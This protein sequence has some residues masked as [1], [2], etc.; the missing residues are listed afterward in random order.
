MTLRFRVALF[1]SAIFLL[2]AVSLYLVFNATLMG[3]FLSLENEGVQRN[4]V[5]AQEGIDTL[6]DETALKAEEWG[7]WDDSYNYIEDLN[8]E[9][10]SSNLTFE[11]LDQLHLRHFLMLNME[12]KP[13]KALFLNKES[14]EV[15]DLDPATLALLTQ[16][17]KQ[18]LES[19]HKVG[20][21]V[22]I[23]ELTYV[24][25][26]APLTNSAGDAP[27]RGTILFSRDFGKDAVSKLQ[28][29]ARVSIRIEKMTDLRNNPFFGQSFLKCL[30]EKK[31]VTQSTETEIHS[32]NAVKDISGVPILGLVTSQGRD[33]LVRGLEARDVVTMYVLIFT[34][35]ALAAALLFLNR[36]VVWPLQKIGAQTMEIGELQ[37]DD[38]R[39][40]VV[41]DKEMRNLGNEINRMLDQLSLSKQEVVKARHLAEAANH[42][43]SMFIARVSHELRTPVGG[44]VGINRIIKKK[45]GLS[46]AIRELVEMGDL[47]ANGLLSI[48]D[49]ILDFSKAESGELTFEK[50]T[51][52]LRQVVRETMQT[53][54]GRLEGKYKPEDSE[55]VQL[56]CDIDPNV[57]HMVLGDPTKMRQI[58]TNLLGNAVKFTQKGHIALRIHVREFAG[59][60]AAVL[61]EVSDTGLGIPQEKLHSIFEPFKQA[62]SWT[63]RKFQGTG[64]GLSIVKQFAE[65]LSGRVWVTS[66]QG[67]GSVFSVEL[68]FGIMDEETEQRFAQ[69]PSEPVLVAP[70]SLATE[71]LLRNLGILAGAPVIHIDPFANSLGERELELIRDSDLLAIAEEAV[72]LP[73]IWKALEARLQDASPALLNG[74]I[75]MLRPSN[76]ELRD[77]LYQK[78]M[79]FVLPTP[80]LADDLMRAFRGEL[81][82]ATTSIVAEDEGL[83]LD[84]KLKILVVDDMLTNRIFLEDMLGDAGHE[85]I[86]VNDG[87]E[88]VER[89]SKMLSGDAAD[90]YDIVLTDISMA[91]MNGDE[92][93][94]AVRELERLN[95]N[96]VHIPILAVT[97]HAFKDE[98]EKILEAGVDGVL[99]KP[100]QPN[101]VAEEFGRLLA[102]RDPA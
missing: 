35:V 18:A 82:V 5:R 66:E 60:G 53:V 34:L 88:M 47:T 58:L 86:C 57:P 37:S 101:K 54:A 95:F 87:T 90:Q 9:Y 68:P 102:H 64:L 20:G 13:V 32:I 98:Q 50:I 55:R 21:L 83:K 17:S 16:I 4:A 12:G 1:I 40:E 6:A 84:R 85:V 81:E 49:E 31:T 45:E 30:S 97:A 99:V 61:F 3:G 2:L 94:R 11:A 39:V 14:N 38:L 10:E 67:K 65:G 73:P 29:L 15:A 26:A 8:A 7:T 27:F 89:L 22:R 77:K 100:I 36:S 44:I 74:T 59:S 96:K 69:S 56:V 48:I 80:V 92:A 93:T 42:A 25:G 76:V 19:G 43:K 79:R 23:G 91:I 24:V 72:I 78:G 62:D 70:Q 46:R 71:V 75:G 63:S 28:Q 51:F 41:G 52:D 33:L